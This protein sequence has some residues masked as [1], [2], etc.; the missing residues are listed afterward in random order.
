SFSTYA[1]SFIAGHYPISP[2]L[3]NCIIQFKKV[4]TRTLRRKATLLNAQKK[5]SCW[6]EGFLQKNVESGG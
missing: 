6:Q 1:T 2:T 5:P 4:N 3:F